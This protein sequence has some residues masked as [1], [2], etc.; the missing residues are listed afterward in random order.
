L[1][2]VV[3]MRTDLDS[4]AR[5]RQTV[6]TDLKTAREEQARVRE[7][8]KTLQAQTDPHA[9]QMK[10]FDDLETQMERL[11]GQLSELRIEEEKKRAALENHLMS[12]EVE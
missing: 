11:S 6:D 1:E 9:R 5:K 3:E 8:L 12:L 10:K 4:L 7:N 2:K